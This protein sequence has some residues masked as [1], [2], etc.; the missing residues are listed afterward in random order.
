MASQ[1]GGFIAPSSTCFDHLYINTFII[2][3][4][5]KSLDEWQKG[6][7][8]TIIISCS[9]S[10]ISITKS[11]FYIIAQ[12]IVILLLG[13]IDRYRPWLQSELADLPV[14]HAQ[15][16]EDNWYI[17]TFVLL[18]NFATFCLFS[19]VLLTLL[20]SYYFSKAMSCHVMS[21]GVWM[22]HIHYNTVFVLRNNDMICNSLTSVLTL[23]RPGQ[24]SRF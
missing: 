13:M 5:T 4:K 11:H 15:H 16:L 2:I 8:T 22:F 7:I 18:R 14:C 6:S 9:L 3:C 19:F 21:A 23:F 12:A 17:H 10:I 24:I 20:M 1:K